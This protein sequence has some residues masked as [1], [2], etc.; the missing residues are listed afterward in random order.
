MIPTIT[1]ELIAACGQPGCPVCRL[2]EGS[3]AGLLRSFFYEKVNDREV[4]VRLRASLGFC[5]EH[6]RQ[7][8]EMDLGDALGSAIVYHDILT[9]ILRNFPTAD[10]KAV[11]ETGLASLLRRTAHGAAAGVTRLV[12][13]LTPQQPCPV[14]TESESANQ[15]YVVELA[16]G[17]KDEALS[18]ALAGSDGLCF[19]HLRQ[20]AGQV[21]DEGVFTFLVENH[22]AR[23]TALN[24]ELAEFIRKNDYRFRSE[25]FGAESD[26]WRRAL[27]WAS[28]AARW[29][30]E[31][32]SGSAYQ[33]RSQN[34]GGTTGV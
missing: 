32:N 14:C 24:E 26:S 18:S 30:G 34:K 13:A 4:R 31:L 22:R 28:A 17:L 2:V 23:L 5:S 21:K 11:N 9:N 3:V 27:E 7:I 8:L 33:E 1:R 19:L 12:L 6:A 16:A 20:V 15:A 29:R 25:R 10:E